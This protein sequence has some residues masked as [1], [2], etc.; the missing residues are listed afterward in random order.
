[1]TATALVFD[2]DDTLYPE[3][4]FVRSGFSA[5]ARWL[6]EQRGIQG[7]AAIA[8]R[9]FESG[10]R[11]RIFD[12]TLE[13]LGHATDPRLVPTLVDVYRSHA[14]QLT[15]FPDAEWALRTFSS[16]AKLGLLTDGYA[17]TQRNKVAALGIARQFAKIVFTD[18][19][20]RE[21]W[22]PS[23]TPFHEVAASLAC[24]PARCVYVADNP[25]KDFVA[26]NRLGWLTVHLQRGTGEY[27]QAGAT[28]PPD[29]H[30]QHQIGS[31]FE[32][33]RVLHGGEAPGN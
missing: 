24:P 4:D 11:G 21:H 3:R 9:L 10:R 26:P 23:P 13:A 22:K 17:Y 20:G 5:V 29:H 16:Q 31:L 7:F 27:H 2:L 8:W 28:V 12:E 18:D 1:M 33:S 25:L 15:L 19:L 30:A 14:P 32:L 6:N